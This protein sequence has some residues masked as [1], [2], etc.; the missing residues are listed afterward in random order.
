MRPFADFVAPAAGGSARAPT[1]AARRPA[2]LDTRRVAGWGHEALIREVELSPKPGL[3]DRFNNGAHDDMDL[4]MFRASAAAIEPWLG[5]FFRFG[6]SECDR[7]AVEFLP[8]LRPQGQACERAMLR[9][10]G[11]VNTH[12]GSVFALGLLCAAAGRLAGRGVAADADGL[13]LEVAAICDGLV[14][15]ELRDGGPAATA[16][17]RLYREH[18]LP[19]ARG[20][21]ASGFA[22]VRRHG[23]PAWRR[24]RAAGHGEEGALHA[25]L[26]NL[27]AYNQDTNLVAR[28]GISALQFVQTRARALLAAGGVDAPDH[29][30]EMSRLDLEMIRR[31]ISPG[32]S[33]DLLAVTW[34][35][36]RFDSQ[37]EE[38][39]RTGLPVAHRRVARPEPVAACPP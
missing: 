31:H 35:L 20:E 39:G 5:V 13:C 29:L 10:T 4:A 8:R 14:A 16:G 6:R 2:I 7:P 28:G 24:A 26:L 1:A 23:L 33:A 27:L 36:S 32:G 22:T 19:G 9:A 11:G 21:A 15:R 30:A 38:C 3:V 12:K 17:E 34:F 25:V 37:Q 18:G